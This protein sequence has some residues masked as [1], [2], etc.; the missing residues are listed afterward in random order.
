MATAQPSRTFSN[1]HTWICVT[2]KHPL[3]CKSQRSSLCTL[4]PRRATRAKEHSQ[5][6]QY[7]GNMLLSGFQCTSW[8]QLS[9]ERG[10]ETERVK[11]DE[12]HKGVSW[13]S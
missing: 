8:R 3:E 2:L 12:G 4:N 7:N 1:M 5:K 10:V 6:Q 9:L 11:L 13:Q